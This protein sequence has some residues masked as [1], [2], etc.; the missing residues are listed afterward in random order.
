MVREHISIPAPYLLDVVVGQADLDDFS[1]NAY[2]YLL[3]SRMPGDPL[4]LCQHVMAD[5]DLEDIAYQLK[6]YLSQLRDL[7]KEVNPDNAICNTLGKACRD[8]RV[9]GGQPVGPFIDEAAISL[10]LRFSD[11]SQ[12]PRTQGCFLACRPQPEEYS[13]PAGAW[14]QWSW[15]V[16]DERHR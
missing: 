7:A 5:G 13:G 2:M 3:V 8:P 6:D 12:P 10:L 11:D 1:R 4:Y 16:D 14:P 9:H 15:C